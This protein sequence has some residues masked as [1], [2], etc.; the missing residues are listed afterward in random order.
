MGQHLHVICCVGATWARWRWVGEGRSGP[1]LFVVPTCLG[2]VCSPRSVS[3]TLAPPPAEEPPPPLRLLCKSSQAP[4]G[5]GQGWEASSSSRLCSGNGPLALLV[6][7]GIN[8]QHRQVLGH[9]LFF[10]HWRYRSWESRG[11]SCTRFPRLLPQQ[12]LLPTVGTMSI[13]TSH[14]DLVPWT[15]WASGFSLCL[16]SSCLVQE[17]PP[18]LSQSRG[19]GELTPAWWVPSPAPGVGALPQN[20]TCSQHSGSFWTF[21]GFRT[22]DPFSTFSR[23]MLLDNSTVFHID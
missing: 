13:P 7:K 4:A 9:G 23:F 10:A 19:H 3:D 12:P 22:R 5:G 11:Q 6:M 16:C 17:S 15:G 8:L 2:C 20:K 14:P 21:G 18:H 1:G